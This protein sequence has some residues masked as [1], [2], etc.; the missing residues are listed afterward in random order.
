[1]GTIA[2]DPALAV[3]EVMITTVPQSNMLMSTLTLRASTEGNVTIQC[4]AYSDNVSPAL[5]PEV[6]LMVQGMLE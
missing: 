3:Y 1:M 6:T 2:N 4:V 5:S